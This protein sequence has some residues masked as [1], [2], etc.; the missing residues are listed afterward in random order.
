[1][2]GN[3]DEAEIQSF[4]RRS[5]QG[6]AGAAGSTG[7]TGGIGP[8][9]DANGTITWDQH[10][11]T[12]S[13][14]WSAVAI[15]DTGQY[16]LAG[17]G[18][19]ETYMGR[20]YLSS[21]YGSNW[22]EV[23][24][25]GDADGQWS[26]AAMTPTGSKMIAGGCGSTAGRLYVSIDSGS[27]WNEM[28]PAGDQALWWFVVLMSNDGNTIL[29]GG[30]LDD[31]N[32]TPVSYL[33]TNGGTSWTTLDNGLDMAYGTCDDDA[34][35]ILIST[36]GPTGKLYRSINGGTSFSEI[37]PKGDAA[38]TAW[39]ALAC[40]R[41]GTRLVAGEYEG[42]V[43]LSDDTGASW[44]ETRPLGDESYLWQA[45]ACDASG[46][47]I[48]LAASSG[49]GFDIAGLQVSGNYGVSWVDQSP[50]P[51]GTMKYTIW[52]SKNM[53]HFVS[54]RHISGSDNLF[55][56]G[57]VGLRAV[58]DPV[59]ASFIIDGGGVAI[60]SG[61]KADIH[62]PFNCKLTQTTLLADQSGAIAVDVW[63]D[64]YANFPPTDADSKTTPTI[65]AS[66]IKF[67]SDPLDIDIAANS[68]IRF[69]VDSCSTITRCLVAL[70]LI[71]T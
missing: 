24:P 53:M 55:Y 17:G 4:P 27:T 59:V 30:E 36:W 33:S 10:F 68:T 47:R 48:A 25:A 66:G 71:K 63:I 18:A 31:G 6:P 65:A 9:G 60:T 21:D 51:A 49:G 14:I 12:V 54:Q 38:N 1:M 58:N 32:F 35:V 13:Q 44:E 26:C 28:Q 64:S 42:R 70:T 50:Y 22:S 7:A 52:A 67:Q 40:N 45:A 61:I 16:M 29:A 69:N 5:D 2:K 8:L 3:Q 20:I 11:A 57:A 56:V 39:Y 23:Q 37:K 15:S 34:S 46:Q 19:Y 43:W 41:D 62:V